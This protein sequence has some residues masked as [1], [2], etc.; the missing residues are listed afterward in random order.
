MTRDDLSLLVALD[1]LLRER[2]VTG[3][4]VRLGIKQPAMSAA[5]ARL[6]ATLGDPLFVRTPRGLEPTAKAR[7]MAVPLADALADL[8]AVLEPPD[9]FEPASARRV[10]RLSGGDYTS[11]VILPPL[12][13]ALER[14]APGVD[15]RWR[16]LEKDRA[17]EA[18]E[19]GEVDL[20]FG[21]LEGVPKRFVVEPLL[22]DDFVCAVRPGHPLA[23]D[24]SLDAFARARHVLVT[25]RGDATGAV[26][27][28]LRA[29]GLSRRVALTVSQVALVPAVL[30]RTDLVA[31]LARRA[32]LAL[33]EAAP[34]RLLEPPVP[35]ARWQVRMISPRTHEGDQ[36]LAWLR[37]LIREAAGAGATEP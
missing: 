9:A 36:G 20:A 13:Q 19:E 24:L 21:V 6:R 23:E 1:A 37:G 12:M 15:L 26:D 16:S 31:T 22:T 2:S 35:L 10:F 11:M 4:A 8:R 14:E 5:L 17:L 3:A 33:S 7:A 27:E 32:A 30:R 25:E 29:A 18:L 28:A 34:L